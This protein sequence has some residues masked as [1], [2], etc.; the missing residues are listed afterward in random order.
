VVKTMSKYQYM[1]DRETFKRY[2]KD[3]SRFSVDNRV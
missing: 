1:M 2:A 3:V